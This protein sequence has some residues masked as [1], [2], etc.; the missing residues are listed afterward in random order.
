MRQYESPGGT[1]RIVLADN[2][3]AF[4]ARFGS[5]QHSPFQVGTTIF[6]RVALQL[7]C[8]VDA[9]IG[10]PNLATEIYSV[11]NQSWCICSRGSE[12]LVASVVCQRCPPS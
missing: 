1:I 8:S 4:L 6:L 11:P 2:T 7:D 10:I 3:A 9:A 5:C 12:Q